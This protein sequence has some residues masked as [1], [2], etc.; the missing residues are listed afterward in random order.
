V[1]KEEIKVNVV[2]RPYGGFP[3]ISLP[4]VAF[5]TY[6]NAHNGYGDFA[7]LEQA[8]LADAADFFRRYYPPAN[9]VLAVTGNCTFDQVLEL[10][11][12]HFG[13]IPARSAPQ[14]GSFGE[15]LPKT[16]RR[17]TVGDPLAPMPAVAIGWRAPD[18]VADMQHFLAYSVLSSVLSDGD[19]SR[20]R[21]RLVHRQQVAVDVAC[22]A[23]T[24]G[25]GLTMRDPVLFQTVIYHPGVVSND[26]LIGAVEE[27]LSRL[28][29]DGPTVDE[30]KRVAASEAADHWHE[31]DQVLNRALSLADLE[32]IHGRAELVGELP[33]LIG[34]VT[35][36]EVAAAAAELLAQR[37]TILELAPGEP[38]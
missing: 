3:W 36:E 23:G 35:P 34:R 17:K 30:M 11:E 15:P 22:Y 20:L 13:V 26:A 16:T 8:S 4:E 2:N 32:V 1:V 21:S 38:Q 37:P 12:R 14:L 29:S 5:S 24:F 18:P 28:A 6:P 9:A 10:A 7:H 27:E 31:V 25:D 33:S 19:A